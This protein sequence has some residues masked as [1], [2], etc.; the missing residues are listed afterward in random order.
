MWTY[1]ANTMQWSRMATAS[2]SCHLVTT[3][4][5]ECMFSRSCGTYL[6]VTSHVRSTACQPTK[7]LFSSENHKSHNGRYKR[8]LCVMQSFDAQVALG[9]LSQVQQLR[10]DG[11]ALI[12]DSRTTPRQFC[13][14]RRGKC[15]S[16]HKLCHDWSHLRPQRVPNSLLQTIHTISDINCIVGRTIQPV[17]DPPP[18]IWEI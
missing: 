15:Q 6:I 4:G 11:T 10:I 8:T 17:L 1:A 9:Y 2:S 7:L 12:L 5:T 3:V 14:H 13:S 18:G 16:I